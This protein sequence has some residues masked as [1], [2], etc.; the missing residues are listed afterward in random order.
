M[1]KQTMPSWAVNRPDKAHHAASEPMDDIEMLA[2]EAMEDMNLD[3]ASEAPSET[4][5][6]DA[7]Q[8][9]LQEI[10]RVSLLTASEE[11]E[12][13]ERMERGDAARD[14]LCQSDDMNV[15]LRCALCCDIDS[16]DDARR[17]LIQANLR[18]VSVSPK[19]MLVVGFRCSI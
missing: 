9:Y 19:S 11:I 7:V 17:H 5:I 1:L 13:A 3:A 8:N 6:L 12:L 2:Q 18:L 15:Q 4:P 16:G 14:R 10:G